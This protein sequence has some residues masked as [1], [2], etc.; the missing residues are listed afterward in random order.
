MQEEGNFRQQEAFHFFN[1]SLSVMVLLCLLPTFLIG[2]CPWGHWRLWR[3]NEP[4]LCLYGLLHGLLCGVREVRHL[5][6]VV[7]LAQ[8]RLRWHRK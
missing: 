3:D 7:G 1:L 2:A 6:W 8:Q 4:C 5:E